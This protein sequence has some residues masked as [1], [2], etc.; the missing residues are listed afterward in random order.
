MTVQQWMVGLPV[1]T[2]AAVSGVVNPQ[3][4]FALT[5]AGIQSNSVTLVSD[6]TVCKTQAAGGALLPSGTDGAVAGPCQ[7]GDEIIVA[8]HTGN[9]VNI[10]PQSNGTIGGAAA[11]TVYQVSNGKIGFFLY[12]GSGNW[13]GSSA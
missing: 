13:T 3:T 7:L 2:R 12:L 6:F 8:N 11:N 9:T 1:A 10:Y 5:A 4:N